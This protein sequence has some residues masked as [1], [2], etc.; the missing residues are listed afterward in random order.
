MGCCYCNEFP[1][2][3]IESFQL[4]IIGK[5]SIA[6]LGV[7]IYMHLSDRPGVS[8]V[9]QQPFQERIADSIS[10][11]RPGFLAVFDQD[12][13]PVVKNDTCASTQEFQGLDA[14]NDTFWRNIRMLAIRDKQDVRVNH[15]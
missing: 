6:P 9:L 10:G 11:V 2:S 7:P 15:N 13:V 14:C 12:F 4:D 8:R 1:V 3:M 5:L